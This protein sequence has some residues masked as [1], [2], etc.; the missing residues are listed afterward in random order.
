MKISTKGRYALRLMLDIALND[1]KTPVRIK[2]IAERQQISDKYLEQ[3][4]SS[5]NK[6]GFVKSLRG[7]QGGYRLTKKPEEYTVGMILRLIEGSLAPVACLDDDVNN[8]TRADRCPTLILW[9]KLYEAI[10]EVVDNI[11][12]ADLISWQKN[13]M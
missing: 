5:L 13:M 2:D 9:E 10:S 3:I 8:C 1:A 4:V 12:L 11:T 6:A 7:P